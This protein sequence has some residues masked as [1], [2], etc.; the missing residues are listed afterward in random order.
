MSIRQ[1]VDVKTLENL[2]FVV[3][4]LIVFWIIFGTSAREFWEFCVLMETE[5]GFEVI[6]NYPQFHLMDSVMEKIYNFYWSVRD[7]GLYC[8]C[9]VGNGHSV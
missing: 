4:I 5:G 8:T 3:K 1:L 6:L 2:G 9:L 7:W